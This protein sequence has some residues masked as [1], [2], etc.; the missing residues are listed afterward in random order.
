MCDS[1]GVRRKLYKTISSG[2]QNIPDCLPPN[3]QLWGHSLI[4][5]SFLKELLGF[6]KSIMIVLRAEETVLWVLED[7]GI[8]ERK[9]FLFQ[10]FFYL[11]L[12]ERERER[13]RLTPVPV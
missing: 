12:R 8:M 13:E 5:S 3:R 2:K 1:L 7:D 10:L 9:L 4:T 6:S 11:F